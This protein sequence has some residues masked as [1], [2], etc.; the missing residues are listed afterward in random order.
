MKIALSAVVA[1]VFTTSCGNS[2]KTSGLSGHHGRGDSYGGFDENEDS[3]HLEDNKQYPVRPDAE[4]TPGG[5]CTTPDERRYPEHV[6][7]CE[8]DVESDLKRD[9]FVQY[10]RKLGYQTTHMSRSLFKIDHLIPLCLGG[11][12]NR[13]NLWPQHRT[14]YELTDPIE[15]YLCGLLG[16]G[17]L[18]QAEAIDI[19]RE[20]KQSPETAKQAL[21]SLEARF[22]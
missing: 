8:R 9:I 3:P 19:I 6:A 11:S 4:L 21:R 13:S 17:V 18:K 12:N 15:P 2:A 7:Y 1:V 10:D 16:R 5:V 22:H 20:V 14:I